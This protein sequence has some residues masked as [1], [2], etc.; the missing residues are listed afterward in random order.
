MAVTFENYRAVEGWEQL[1]E[2]FQHRDVADV[3]V[4][5]HDRVFVLTRMD[6]RVIV[7]DQ[8]GRFLKAWGEGLLSDRPHG[9]TVGPADIV[10]VVDEVAHQ[11]RK[12]SPDGV[13]LGEIGS[14]EASDTGYISEGDIK[15][16]QATI[17]RPAGPFNRPTKVAVAQNGDLYVSDGY[18]NSRVHQFS[19]EGELKRSWGEPGTG[20]GQFHLPHWVWVTDDDRVLVTDRE[21][22]RIQVFT[23]DGDFVEIWSKVQRPTA[24]IG[25]GSGPFFVTELPRPKGH[26]SWTLGE[27]DVDLPARVTVLDGDGTVLGR[28]GAT[29]EPCAAGNVA[30]PHGVAIDSHGDLYIA[31]VTQTFLAGTAPEGCHTLQKLSAGA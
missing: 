15:V 23:L 2:G 26:Y 10:Y 24:I 3:A 6:P 25:K 4:D 11:V 28:F 8:D 16:R 9:I 7:Y 20:P 31:E 22:D 1:P 18:G 30:A 19:P 27:T 21:N 13:P 29:G 5:S 17:A 14:G 12:F